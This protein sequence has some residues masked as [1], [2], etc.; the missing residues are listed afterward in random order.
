MAALGGGAV[1]Y[2]RG[3]P[4]TKKTQLRK[5]EAE[6]EKDAEWG[7]GDGVACGVGEDDEEAEE[8]HPTVDES[9]GRNLALT[10]LHVPHSLA[11]LLLKAGAA[12]GR[13]GG[14]RVRDFASLIF[15]RESSK[16]E[17]EDS[18]GGGGEEGR[19]GGGERAQKQRWTKAST[20]SYA[21]GYPQARDQPRAA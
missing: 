21:G 3:T 11:A 7:G 13:R 15:R 8:K 20:R 6:E 10:V 19:R 5:E 2:E 17:K 12:L 1:S 18:G 9:Q 4:V 14:G 16:D